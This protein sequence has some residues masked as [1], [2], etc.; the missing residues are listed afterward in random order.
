MFWNEGAE[1]NVRP[2]LALVW[3]AILMLMGIAVAW[4]LL[5]SADE[6]E[7]TAIGM[8]EAHGH[9]EES[10]VVS[11][12]RFDCEQVFEFSYTSNR[13]KKTTSYVVMVSVDGSVVALARFDGEIECQPTPAG[14]M[15]GVF[16]PLLG[17]GPLGHMRNEGLHFPETDLPLLDFDYTTAEP[18]EPWMYIIGA[19]IFLVTGAQAFRSGARGRRSR[20]S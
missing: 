16:K 10:V 18:R 8:D 17:T 12:A 2:R 9:L 7:P 1:Q 3:G 13:V 20:A 6:K 11:G 15:P 14:P 19:I 4:D 5:Q